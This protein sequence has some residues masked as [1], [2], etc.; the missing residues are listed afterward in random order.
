M[1]P[2]RASSSET[3]WR[4]PRNS[5]GLWWSGLGPG[6]QPADWVL[7]FEEDPRSFA[8]LSVSN[9]SLIQEVGQK[10]EDQTAEANSEVKIH[11]SRERALSRHPRIS[12]RERAWTRPEILPRVESAGVLTAVL[13]GCTEPKGRR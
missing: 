2:H 8:L 4:L 1:T 7:L 13:A 9:I 11:R 10:L 3:R 5:S 6:A 12:P